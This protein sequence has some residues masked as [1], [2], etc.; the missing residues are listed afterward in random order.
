[1]EGKFKLDC[2]SDGIAE[3]QKKKTSSHDVDYV[4]CYEILLYNAYVYKNG[5]IKSTAFVL[6]AMFLNICF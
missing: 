1:M 2:Q 5:W 4:L 6:I 3:H